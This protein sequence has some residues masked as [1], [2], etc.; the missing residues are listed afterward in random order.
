MF[1][2]FA[3][4]S[5]SS[6]HFTAICSGQLEVRPGGRPEPEHELARI[7]LGKQLG[8]ELQAHQ[9]EDQPADRQVAGHHDPAPA[10]EQLDHPRE[11][12]LS[13]AI[14][15]TLRLLGLASCA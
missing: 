13:I 15:K 1:S 4:C 6:R 7:D 11:D 2:G 9:P 3:S 14:E 12:V 8:A 5:I 10:D